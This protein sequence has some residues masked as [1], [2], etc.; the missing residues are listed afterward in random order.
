MN[1]FY[2]FI[3]ALLSVSGPLFVS[4]HETSMTTKST[5]CPMHHSTTTSYSTAATATATSAPYRRHLYRRHVEQ[6]SPPASIGQSSPTASIGQSILAYLKSITAKDSNAT[7]NSTPPNENTASDSDTTQ[8]KTFNTLV[9]IIQSTRINTIINN[10]G[11]TQGDVV[12]FA[13]TD[14]AFAALPIPIK[15]GSAQSCNSASPSVHRGNTCVGSD[16]SDP[17]TS[18]PLSNSD[19]PAVTL[20]MMYHIHHGDAIT[21]PKSMMDSSFSTSNESDSIESHLDHPNSNTAPESSF[22]T[23]SWIRQR[24]TT[25]LDG[26]DMVV[27]LGAPPTDLESTGSR[28]IKATVNRNARILNVHRVNNVLVVVLDRVVSPFSGCIGYDSCQGVDE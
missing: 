2:T 11:S 14:Q 26:F 16:Q 3:I 4:G 23:P 8:L 19:D 24:V 22:S 28:Q 25:L 12:L 13:P 18:H 17:I 5:P 27:E 6:P 21:F 1:C 9:S 10:L 7:P 15:P 20:L